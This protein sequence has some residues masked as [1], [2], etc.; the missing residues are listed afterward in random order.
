MGG[1]ALVGYAGLASAQTPATGSTTATSTPWGMHKGAGL[2]GKMGGMGRGVVGTVSAV[3][4]NTITLTDKSGKT[5]T[6]DASNA[7]ISKVVDLTVGDIKVGDT[8]GVQGSVSGTTVTAKHVMDG[9]PP[10][11]QGPPAQ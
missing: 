5:Y 7:K 3:N 8:L 4:G 11:P 2:H 1:G 6:V 9:V 10:T